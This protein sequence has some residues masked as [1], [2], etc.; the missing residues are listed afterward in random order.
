MGLKGKGWWFGDGEVTA[1]VV[2]KERGDGG[3]D[4][5]ITDSINIVNVA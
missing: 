2:G 3:N 5:V 1:V 4:N